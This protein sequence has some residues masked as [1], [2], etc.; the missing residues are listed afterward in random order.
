MIKRIDAVDITNFIYE[1]DTGK[2]MA[3]K[4]YLIPSTITG[5]AIFNDFIGI[6]L[7]TN[8]YLRLKNDPSIIALLNKYF[9]LDEG[10]NNGN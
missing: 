6:R 5:M 7:S 8:E 2:T 9:N 4:V 3:N 10:K 1:K